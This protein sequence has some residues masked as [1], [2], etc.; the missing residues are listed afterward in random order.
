MIRVLRTNACLSYHPNCLL[1]FGRLQ[2]SPVISLQP[3][4]PSH[5]GA[6]ET[7]NPNPGAAFPPPCGLRFGLWAG[8]PLP[9]GLG[10]A[11]EPLNLRVPGA[12]GRLPCALPLLSGQLEAPLFLRP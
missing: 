6:A 5:F 2:G 12:E 10:Q 9:R 1:Q 8:Q 7:T 3:A 11:F 4:R